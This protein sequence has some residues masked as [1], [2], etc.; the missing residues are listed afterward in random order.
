MK[1]K[2]NV[3]DYVIQMVDVL[4]K[5]KNK[6]RIFSLMVCMLVTL[7]DMFTMFQACLETITRWPCEHCNRFLIL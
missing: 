1:Y 7:K 3:F 2:D 5:L 4:V 6:N